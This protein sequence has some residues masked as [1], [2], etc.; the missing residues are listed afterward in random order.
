[1]ARAALSASR[2]LAVLNFL[3]AHADEAFTLS[4]LAGRL[5]INLAS[6]HAVLGVLTDSGYVVRHPRLRTFTLGPSVVALGN[7][8]L[9]RAP[10]IDLAREAATD[11]ATRLG[12]EVAV[13]APAGDSIVFLARAGEHQA[14]GFPVYI[15]QRVP[16]APPLGSVFVAWGDTENWLAKAEDP[17][18]LRDV[19]AGVRARGYAVALEVDA[20]HQLGLTLEDLADHPTDM[21]LRHTVGRIVIDLG[22]EPYQ[23]D[24]LEP[25]QT[26]DVSGIAAPV[27]DNNGTVALALTLVGFPGGLTGQEVAAYGVRLRDIGIVLTKKTAGR[28]PSPVSVTLGTASR[29]TAG[30]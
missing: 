19:L 18:P 20:R 17:A 22:R 5:G 24:H 25:Q 1:M 26:Y 11:L 14:R 23:I 28:L 9:E 16:L 7:A 8:A 4:D 10:V 6:A 12:L 21:G 2:A 30:W 27:F 15:G 3:A 13:T 29:E